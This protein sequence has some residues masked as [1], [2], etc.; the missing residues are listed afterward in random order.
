[1]I[2]LGIIAGGRV[3]QAPLSSLVILPTLFSITEVSLPTDRTLDGRDISSYLIDSNN[4]ASIKTPLLFQVE[5]DLSE[6][7]DRAQAQQELTKVL[8]EKLAKFLQH[9]D[10]EGRF[11]HND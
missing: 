11:W 5:Q 3:K 7:I 2:G 1:M 9:I 4:Q 8:S 10:A 6:S